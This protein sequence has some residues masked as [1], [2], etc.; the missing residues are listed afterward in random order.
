MKKR[1]GKRVKER[2]KLNLGKN[3]KETNEHRSKQESKRVKMI[4]KDIE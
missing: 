1:I 2:K 3:K 4:E